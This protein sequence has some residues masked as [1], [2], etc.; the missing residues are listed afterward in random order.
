ME[1]ERGKEDEKV[2]GGMGGGGGGRV[3]ITVKKHV[4]MQLM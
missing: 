4:C 1:R 3:H 2:D